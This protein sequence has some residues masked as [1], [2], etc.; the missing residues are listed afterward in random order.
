MKSWIRARITE[1]GLATLATLLVL[2]PMAHAQQGESEDLVI[3]EITV[4]AQ[5]REQSLME[6]PISITAFTGEDIQE[7]G[8][9]EPAD[10]IAKTPNVNA[11]SVFGNAFPIFWIRGIGTSDQAHGANSPIGM[12]ANEIY[13][14]SL[15]GQ[16][17][18]LFDL[19]RVEVLR[20]PQGTLWG[21][22]TTGGAMNFI[23]KTPGSQFEGNLL[24]EYGLYNDDTPLYRV[25]GGVSMPLSDTLST[26]IAM[27]SHQRDDWVTNEIKNGR[28]PQTE[29]GLDGVS[30]FAGRVTFVWAPRDGFDAT[31]RATIGRRDGDHVPLHFEQLDNPNSFVRHGGY[32]EDPAID[33]VSQDRPQPERVEYENVSLHLNL[34][35][36]WGTLTSISGFIHALYNQDADVDG[37]PRDGL[38]GP[39]EADSE[40]FSQELRATLPI[41]ERADLIAGAYYFTEDMDGFNWFLTGS[42]LG[43]NNPNTGCCENSGFGNIEQRE[44]NS[45]AF[46]G[47]VNYQFTDTLTLNAGLRYTEDE[48]DWAF[49]QLFWIFEGSRFNDGVPDSNDV[50]E[51]FDSGQLSESWDEIT[52]DV[53]LTWSLSDDVNVYG[54][55]ARGYLSG[56]HVLPFTGTF[57]SVVEPE[58]IDSLEFGVKGTYFEGLLQSNFAVYHYD[59]TNIQ[60]S[61]GTTEPT[62]GGFISLRENAAEATVQGFEFDLTWR[63]GENWLVRAGGGY[64]DTEF[65]E[66]LSQL[67]GGGFEDY[68]GRE[69]PNVPKT[70][71]FIDVRYNY[72]LDNGASVEIATDWN[73]ADDYFVDLNYFPDNIGESRTLGNLYLRYHSPERNWTATLYARNVADEEYVVNRR[74]FANAIEGNLVIYGAPRV[75]GVSLGIDF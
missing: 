66:F 55:F 50:S 71:G 13:H 29:E 21:K 51:L 6:V 11:Y 30:E 36:D 38:F 35:R 44:R 14:S 61:R 15:V 43:P 72:P 63:P 64:T 9:T 49:Q 23:S 41:G 52:G 3:E 24:A 1:G 73:Y 74:D 40:Q 22:N 34:E 47:S 25:Q 10:I 12:Y 27:F 31:F 70:T 2:S 33:V 8:W 26:R 32:E 42:D 69:F 7:S 67:P 57:Y 17:F 4:T 19:E 5:K 54:K 28:G 58:E 48:E 18:A 16:G 46:F 53:S 45:Y 39:F 59:Y 62:Q 60:V 56:N 20:G 65:D 37:T 68:S 75:L